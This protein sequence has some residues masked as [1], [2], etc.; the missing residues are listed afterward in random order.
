MQTRLQLG[1]FYGTILHARQVSRFRLTESSFAPEAIIPSHAH[2]NA[3]F[4]IFM[5]GG[6]QES[7][8]GQAYSRSPVQ[9]VLHPVGELH[10]NRIAPR[11]ARDLSVELLPNRLAQVQDSLR[12][13]DR[14]DSF[15]HLAR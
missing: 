9:L 12:L 13:F 2:A 8:L 15:V 10:S 6:Y 7:S 14:P 4:C 1:E 5:A 11:G 3:H